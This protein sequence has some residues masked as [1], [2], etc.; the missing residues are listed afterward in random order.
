MATR[1]YNPLVEYEKIINLHQKIQDGSHTRFFRFSCPVS[2]QNQSTAQSPTPISHPPNVEEEKTRLEKLLRTTLERK[3]AEKEAANAQALL[4]EKKRRKKEKRD[5]KKTRNLSHISTLSTF[6]SAS[7]ISSNPSQVITISS[8][9]VDPSVSAQTDMTAHG[10]PAAS[11]SEFPVVEKTTGFSIPSIPSK[12]PVL[13]TIQRTSPSLSA[14]TNSSNR[15]LRASEG[16]PSDQ[17]V[18]EIRAEHLDSP[19]LNLDHIPANNRLYPR[20][21]T[22][23]NTFSQI[24]PEPLQH[25]LLEEGEVSPSVPPNFTIINPRKP[26]GAQQRKAAKLRRQQTS[27][28]NDRLLPG[29]NLR[30]TSS[31]TIYRP[32]YSPPRYIKEEFSPRTLEFN[33]DAP[34]PPYDFRISDPG[35]RSPPRRFTDYDRR[36]IEMDRFRPTP[37]DFDCRLSELEND[38]PVPCFNTHPYFEERMVLPPYHRRL[39][40]PRSSPPVRGIQDPRSVS[41]YHGPPA[42]PPVY[43][44][45]PALRIGD[46]E[47]SRFYTNDRSVS[48]ENPVL[49]ARYRRPVPDIPRRY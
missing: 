23:I 14:P 25:V 4:E 48:Y 35:Y 29:G 36:P 31:D 47:P 39:V 7:N 34:R 42:T 27:F 13:E 24:R 37:V 30:K 1:S 12:T 21:S 26:S 3:K 44:R 45:E 10:T 15:I 22:D 28:V 2:Q 17:A 6:S 43:Y 32:P 11:L 8:S 41:P 16:C 33:G 46:F 18:S 5:R 19:K 49:D 20:I 38:R 9:P 40:Y